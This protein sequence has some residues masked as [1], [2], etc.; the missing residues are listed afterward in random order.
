LNLIIN[1]GGLQEYRKKVFSELK[2]PELY[3]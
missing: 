2:Q 1:S 3:Y